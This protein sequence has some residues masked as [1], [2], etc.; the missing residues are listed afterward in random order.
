MF[1]ARPGGGASP[2]GDGWETAGEGQAAGGIKF[3]SVEVAEARFPLFFE[4]H[5]FRADSGGDGMHRGGVGAELRLRVESRSRRWPTPP[6][7][8]SAM[9]RT[10]CSAAGRPAASLSTSLSGRP[11]RVLKTKEVGIVVRPGDVFFVESS[12]GG[13]YGPPGDAPPKRASRTPRTVSSPG[14]RDGQ[15]GVADDLLESIRARAHANLFW[16]YL[17]IEVDAAGEGWIKLR[18]PIHDELRNGVGAPVHGGVLATV[19]DAAVGGALGTYGTAAAGGV[20]QATLDLNVTYIAAARGD[21]IF[22]EG[23]IIRRG[24]SVAFGE[25]RVT[26]ASGTLVAVGRATYMIIQPRT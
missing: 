3:G 25:T 7:T 20:D 5:E 14:V 15:A 22:A 12:G 16:R 8:A 21:A 1:H 24:R 11:D 2:V 26:D 4:H 18:V 13:G 19:V 9:R 17:G 10:A 23:K 6:A